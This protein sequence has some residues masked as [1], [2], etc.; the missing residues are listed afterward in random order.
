MKYD[1]DVV[2]SRMFSSYNNQYTITGSD[3]NTYR[4]TINTWLY[5]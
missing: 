4:Y 5:Q 3:Y 1:I 2:L